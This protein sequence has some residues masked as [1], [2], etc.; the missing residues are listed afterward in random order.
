MTNKA[1]VN[2]KDGNTYYLV[3]GIVCVAP[4]LSIGGYDWTVGCRVSEME[5]LTDDLL[6][7]LSEYFTTNKGDSK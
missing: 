3:D 6:M 4:T 2:T 1:W 5:G 7:E